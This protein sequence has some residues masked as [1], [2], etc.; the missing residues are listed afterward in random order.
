MANPDR[1]CRL[2]AVLSR[3]SGGAD[4]PRDE[5]GAGQAGVGER[6]MHLVEF[7][8]VEAVGEAGHVAEAVGG[9]DDR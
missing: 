8:R 1:H 3:A 2:A 5:G 7:C 6:G 9:L 4:P